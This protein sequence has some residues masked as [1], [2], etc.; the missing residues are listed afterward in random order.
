MIFKQTALGSSFTR[1]PIP[2]H[3]Q[4]HFAWLSIHRDFG[5]AQPPKADPPTAP[6]KSAGCRS[7]RHRS[8]GE[9][10]QGRWCT[11]APRWRTSVP[12]SKGESGTKCQEASRKS[13][14][15]QMLPNKFPVALESRALI[16][17]KS[18]RFFGNLSRTRSSPECEVLIFKGRF[19]DSPVHIFGETVWDILSIAGLK[20]GPQRPPDKGPR[21]QKGTGAWMNWLLSWT[22]IGIQSINSI[23]IPTCWDQQR[24]ILASCAWESP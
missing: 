20:I 9:P 21:P 5:P 19:A 1:N 17:L 3:P 10:G 13:G 24:S 8:R 6:P 23:R 4:P 18:R 11:R 16:P 14:G 7:E 12:F 2:S 22:E 15:Y